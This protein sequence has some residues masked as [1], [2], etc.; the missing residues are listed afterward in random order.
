[1][2][3]W[4]FKFHLNTEKQHSLLYRAEVN[5]IGVQK[6][7]HTT[8][9]RGKFDKVEVYYFIDDD[10]REFRSEEELLKALAEGR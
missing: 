9:K 2:I 8:F 10:D 4:E 5:G 1:M 7:V 6:E 3:N